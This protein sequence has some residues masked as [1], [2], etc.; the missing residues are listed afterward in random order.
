MSTSSRIISGSAASWMRILITLITQIAL[1][2]I[3]LS[4]W[5]V[6]VYG[7]WIAIQAITNILTTLDKGY[8]E[9]LGY[10]FLK[11]GKEDRK[12][13]NTY[14]WSGILITLV[15]GI[16]ELLLV[17]FLSFSPMM[18]FFLG[19]K[20]MI[21]SALLWQAGWILVLQWIGWI[22]FS[23]T[24]GLFFRAL[25]VYGYYPRMGWWNVLIG[26]ITSL[27]P[28]IA[29]VLGGNL[30]VAGFVST[31]SLLLITI[32]Q[33]MD[34]IRLLKK[35]GIFDRS[36]SLKLGLKNY[37]TSLLLSANF[38]LDNFRQQGVRLILSPLVGVINLTIFS[39]IRTA[40]NV[41]QQGLLTITQP[42]LPEL[43]RFIKEKN[44]QKT[45]I[46]FD[47]VWIVLVV[48][49]SPFV[50]ILQAIAEPLFLIWTKN[51][52]P[53]NAPLFAVLSISILIYAFAQPAFSISLGNNLLS[54]QI[55]VSLITSIVISGG[56]VG[57][58]PFI[59]LLGTG[60][61]LLLA[62]ISAAIAYNIFATRWLQNNNLVWPKQTSH[63]ALFS[64][65]IA[66]AST[67][68]MLLFSNLKWLILSLSVILLA[69]NCKRYW[70]NMSELATQK[71][72]AFAEKIPFLN[73][74]VPQNN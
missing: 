36:Y 62:E 58:T 3:Y 22:F 46:A 51:Q 31:V 73:N 27:T 38:F 17:C 64:V 23:N 53:F 44:Q 72:R 69:W 13:I 71:I 24:T 56:I 11:A 8:V 28:V 1:V 39:T 33:Y 45:E 37:K 49:L 5:S 14:L 59:G 35:E 55:T 34:I 61:S 26:L 47:T 63:I 18:H 16:I 70:N 41:V 65:Y 29:V 25:A 42:V 54:K 66:A 68:A 50:V 74:F 52:I 6:K 43:M 4:Y 40:A 20:D 15:F 7:I 32:P 10:E 19:K 12:K 21:E 30:L 9:F 60:I 57:L 67:I 48:F 2:P